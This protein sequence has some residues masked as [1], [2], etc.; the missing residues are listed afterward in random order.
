[1]ALGMQN[2]AIT[3]NLPSEIVNLIDYSINDIQREINRYF[4]IKYYTSQK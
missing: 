3:I 1:M 2:K 4:A